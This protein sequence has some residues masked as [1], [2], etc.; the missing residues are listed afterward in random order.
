LD[1]NQELTGRTYVAPVESCSMTGQTMTE[2]TQECIPVD[3]YWTG[4][5]LICPATGDIQVLSLEST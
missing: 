4:G 3:G 2:D 5:T 1:E